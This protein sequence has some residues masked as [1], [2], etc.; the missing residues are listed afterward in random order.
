MF[1]M[2]AEDA[3]QDV[4]QASQ[5]DLFVIR[6]NTMEEMG[7]QQ[8]GDIPAQI[9][10]VLDE[11]KDIGV[12]RKL[13]PEDTPGLQRSDGVGVHRIPLVD[14]AVPHKQRAIPMSAPQQVILQELLQDLVQKGYIVPVTGYSAWAAPVLVVK[15]QATGRG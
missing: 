7:F 2:S 13:L 10:E 14:R 11:Y 4:A 1:H 12:F 3:W 8:K 6:V 9:Q 15:S 5:E